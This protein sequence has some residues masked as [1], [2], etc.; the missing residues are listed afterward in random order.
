M[1]GHTEIVK[2]PRSQGSRDG[3]AYG[4]DPKRVENGHKSVVR[5]FL[6]N[7]VNALT[8]DRD[9]K[10]DNAVLCVDQMTCE[11]CSDAAGSRV[12]RRIR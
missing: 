11:Y 12:S 6:E 3:H 1:N 4:T 8:I 7:G 5:P 9:D 10:N 2:I